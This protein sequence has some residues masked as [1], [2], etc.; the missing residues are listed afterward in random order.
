MPVDKSKDPV[1]SR[2]TEIDEM[3]QSAG[4]KGFKKASKKKRP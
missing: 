1:L 4:S 2:E 3:Y